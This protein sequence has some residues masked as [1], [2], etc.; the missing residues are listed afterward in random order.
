MPCVPVSPFLSHGYLSK[1]LP[2]QM[3]RAVGVIDIGRSN[4]ACT[5]R[6]QLA[7]LVAA[8]YADTGLPI[9]RID[10]SGRSRMLGF[11]GGN[12]LEHALSTSPSAR[13]A[14][15]LTWYGL[16]RHHRGGRGPPCNIRVA[17]FAVQNRFFVVHL[18]CFRA[19]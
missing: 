9:L 6:D 13:V 5:L 17:Y 2:P 7:K 18:V 12:E 19:G 4:T 11:I 3:D 15:V 16:S 1:I 14:Q 8:G 10:D